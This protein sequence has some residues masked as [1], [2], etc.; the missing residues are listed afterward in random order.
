MWTRD[1]RTD[2]DGI[3]GPVVLIIAALALMVALIVSLYFFP[4]YTIAA[5]LCVGG[6]VV[7]IQFMEMKVGVGM[8]VGGLIVGSIAVMQTVGWL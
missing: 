8:I 4:W 6:V 1:L 7:M 3:V 2:T 5:M